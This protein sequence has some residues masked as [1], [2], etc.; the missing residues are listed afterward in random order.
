MS[1]GECRVSDPG[2]LSLKGVGAVIECNASWR[3]SS[4]EDLYGLAR[5]LTRHVESILSVDIDRV[6]FAENEPIGL[7]YVLFKYRLYPKAMEGYVSCR[8]VAQGDVVKLVVCTI[9]L[10]LSKH[11]TGASSEPKLVDAPKY[12]VE[13]K[14]PPGQRYVKFFTI[15]RILGQPKVDVRKWR[16][17]ITGLVGKV[18]ELS[19][20]ELQLMPCK[21]ILVDFHCV[22]G[23]SV[24]GVRWSGVPLRYL[25]GLVEVKDNARW[26]LVKGLDGY[27]ATIPVEDFLHEDSLLA[28]RLN[29]RPL[30]VEQGFPARIVI[31]HLYGWKGVKWVSEIVFMDKYVDGFWEKLGYHPRGNVWLEE[32]FKDK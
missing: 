30:S 32:R 31:P 18:V 14:L 19:Y 1:L 22:T 7:N 15:Y 4:L 12:N 28:L 13:G 26:V 23:W 11:G 24:R 10:E 16:L 20:D 17:R 27:T 25:A 9:P 8:L 5:E 6:E 21:E 29:S 2:V 3:Y